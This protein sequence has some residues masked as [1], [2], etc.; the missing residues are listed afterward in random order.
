MKISI[1]FAICL[2][3]STSAWAQYVWI[4]ENGRKQYSDQA[5]PASVPES[6]ILK[7]KGKVRDNP[8]PA[9]A[10]PDEKLKQPETLAEKDA[11]YKKRREELLA[12]EKKEEADAK[13][14]KAKSDYCKRAKEYK[15][16][17]ESG[18]PIENVDAA[19]AQSY[20]TDEKRA[21]DLNELRQNMSECEK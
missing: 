15:Q 14:A 13:T 18:Q 6:K 8:N 4:D 11:A 2:A 1:A 16:I 19:G 9:P 10:K 12:K 21:Q 5:P 7:F 17:L 20:I 3:I